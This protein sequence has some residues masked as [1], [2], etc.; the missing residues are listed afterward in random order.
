[1][2]TTRI[3]RTRALPYAIAWLP[4][5]LGIAIGCGGSMTPPPPGGE[6]L[7]TGTLTSSAGRT[8]GSMVA[9]PAA[10]SLGSRQPVRSALGSAGTFSLSLERGR[11][12]VIAAEA[13]GR[14]V[15]VLKFPAAPGGPNTALLAVATD[16]SQSA[17]ID[18]GTVD[19]TGSNQEL[20]ST[21]NPLNQND[22]DGDGVV[23]FMDQDDDGDAMMDDSDADD[24]GDGIADTMADLDLD[25]DGL[26]DAVDAD[27]ENDGISDSFD[28]DDDGD[29]I[30]DDNEVDVDDDGIARDSD[31]DQDGDGITNAQDADADGDGMS[32]DPDDTDHDGMRNNQD[33][34][35]DNDGLS[36][37][38]DVD[39][40]NDGIP[41]AID[42]D[43]NN[44]GIPDNIL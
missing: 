1:M 35:D 31:E 37:D 40:D 27:D 6:R 34:D 43:D 20:T 14:L 30:I 39:D 7:V 10:G 15:A 22:W 17:G 24:D 42:M 5:V 44:D 11:R 41:D 33:S 38:V 13:G 19:D 28:E 32:D 23:D 26:I 3:R 8:L 29:G 9:L 16:A 12:Y 25:N 36:D 2:P 4:A 18:L 21:N